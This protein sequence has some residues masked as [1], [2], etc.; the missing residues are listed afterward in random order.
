MILRVFQLGQESAIGVALHQ[1][2]VELFKH[3]WDSLAHCLLELFL[4]RRIKC[5]LICKPTYQIVLN[6]CHIGRTDN[7][8]IEV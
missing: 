3:E 8:P 7:S 5:F 4:L 2:T 6:C 1:Q